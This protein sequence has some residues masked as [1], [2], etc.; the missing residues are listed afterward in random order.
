MVGD[1]VLEP[2][3]DELDVEVDEL[4]P[5]EPSLLDSFFADEPFDEPPVDEPERLSVR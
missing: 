3:D 2:E 1:V 5:A 4:L